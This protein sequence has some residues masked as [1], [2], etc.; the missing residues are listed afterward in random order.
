MEPAT[1]ESNKSESPTWRSHLWRVVRLIP[2][3]L[4]L[5]TLIALTILFLMGGLRKLTAWYLL[6]LI[7]PLLGL[8]A[9]IAIII[10]VIVKRRYSRLLIFTALV[11]LISLAPAITLIRP[12]AFPASIESS[13]PSATVRLPADAPLRVAWG[14][15]SIETNYHAA[16]PDQRWAYDL[17][18]EPYLTGSS[19]LEDYGCYGIPVVAPVS[20]LVVGVRDGEP[21]EPPGITSNN[22]IAPT[23]NH[24]FIQMETGTYLVIAHL[25]EGSVRVRTGENVEEGQAIGECGNSGNTSEPHIHIHHQ[26][27][28]PTVFP[29]NFAEG[30]PL[31]FRE[32]DG[33]PMPVGGIKVEGDTIIAT[34]DIV[35]HIG[36]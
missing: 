29:I 23:G 21:D 30:L 22:V 20:G 2:V 12:I 8:I 31:Y 4:M 33:A 1:L 19:D 18:V 7:P 28:D 11:A 13:A 9:I 27:Q 34:G 17:L 36:K 14:G 35:Q 15:D 3:T 25:K 6:Q 24:V 16:A 32:H 26:R 5:I 10:Y